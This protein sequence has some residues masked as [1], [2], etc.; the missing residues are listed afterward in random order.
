MED[1][2]LLF[3]SQL[4]YGSNLLVLHLDSYFG[5]GRFSLSCFM[6]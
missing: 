6:L 2:I 3:Y 1:L 4:D 5:L